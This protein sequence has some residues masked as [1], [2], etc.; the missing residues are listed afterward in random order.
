[1]RTYNYSSLNNEEVNFT[2]PDNV[3]KSKQLNYI[4]QKLSRVLSKLK[5]IK[6]YYFTHFGGKSRVKYS[7]FIESRFENDFN[8]INN[9]ITQIEILP[10]GKS[11]VLYDEIHDSIDRIE[12]K[13]EK[14]QPNFI[15]GVLKC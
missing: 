10:I 3:S 11:N 14:S 6:N 8:E 13:V 5:I 1:M 15:Q 2:F 4:T 12:Y 9:M 7:K